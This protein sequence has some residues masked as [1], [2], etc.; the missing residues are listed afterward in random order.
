M[1]IYTMKTCIW[2]KEAINFLKENKIEFEK[3]DVEDNKKAGKE[4]VKISGQESVP[5]L[6]IDGQIII[7]F[8]EE[9]IRKAIKDTKLEAYGGKAQGMK[10]QG[11][12]E[13]TPQP[14]S[15][16]SQKESRIDTKT[17]CEINDICT[18]KICK[19]CEFDDPS[20]HF[21]KKWIP[22]ND[23]E[24]VID[25]FDILHFKCSN[26]NPS[27]CSE[28]SHYDEAKAKL[29]KELGINSKNSKDEQ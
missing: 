5:V 14:S 20:E 4:M 12:G 26:C 6:D 2:C 17:S 9:A 15:L 8:D 3:I 29:K 23:A 24:K 28:D 16:N 19:D 21:S 13:T 11:E 25:E 1:K 7:G 22:A 18:D 10:K 27:G